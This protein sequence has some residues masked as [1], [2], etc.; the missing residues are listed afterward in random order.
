MGGQWGFCGQTYVAQSPNIDCEEAINC[1]CEKSEGS[2]AKTPLALLHTPGRKIFAQLPES[3][4]PSIAS[5]NGRTFAACANLWELGGIGSP[6]NRGSLGVTPIKPSQIK[7]NE[8]QA[9]IMN[10]GNLYVFTMATNA[11]VAVNMAQFNGPVM[12]IEFLDGYF[13]ALLEN[14]HTFQVSALKDGT[15]WGGLDIATISLSPDN[16]VSMKVD[17]RVLWFQSSKKSFGYY[18]VGA[19]A[20][21]FIPIQDAVVENG[22]GVTFATVQLDN[23]IMYLDQDER[24]YMVARRLS[25]YTPQ[26]ISNH[27]VE[28]AWQ[29]YSKVTDAVGWTYQADGHSFWNIWFQTA[30][31]TWTFDV[32]TGLWHKR[33]FWDQISGKYIADRAMSHTF[34]F[35]MHLVG[36]WASGNV[37]QLSN[38][39]YTDFDNPIRGL[40]RCPL[41]TKEN[42]WIYTASV[43]IDVECGIAPQPPLLDGNGNPRPPQLMMR[44]S[45]DAA[46]NWGNTWLIPCGFS[47]ETTKRA[48]KVMLGR[49]RRPVLE[50]AW[51]DP[52]PWRF[53][54]AYIKA[55]PASTGSI[56]Q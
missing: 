56:G 42:E 25:G 12:Q 7:F 55:Y 45:R 31:V 49:A 37:Y 35:G 40:R 22:A 44:F 3:W 20:P 15:T 38:A 27:S 53:V 6:T 26:R 16:I 32:S 33:L 50:V 11:L 13:I 30:N 9:L 5:E 18:N 52:I 36:D 29:G 19:G 14:S 21:P 8:T 46:K 43:E 23:S 51:T 47:G 2:A 17:H 24:G 34:N 39:I 1:Y 28:T 10:N 41:P 48:R 54:D 4:V